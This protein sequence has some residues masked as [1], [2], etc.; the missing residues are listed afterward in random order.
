MCQRTPDQDKH[1]KTQ[2]NFESNYEENVYSNN[3]RL[4][5]V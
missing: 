2:W 5:M 3:I 1:K 4:V